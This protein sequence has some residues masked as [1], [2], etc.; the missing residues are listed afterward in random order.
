MVEAEIVVLLAGYAAHKRFDR[1]VGPPGD[2]GACADYEAAERWTDAASIPGWEARADA[3][4]AEHWTAIVALA[5]A[6]L[7]DEHLDGDE[8]EIVV[9]I[10]DGE[11]RPG[12][13]DAYR[14]RRA[15]FRARVSAKPRAKK[16]GR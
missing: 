3:F 9:D 11:A 6:L 8:A 2:V 14:M 15:E 7:R 5:D 16:G 1:D 10:H 13:L 12:D 4:V